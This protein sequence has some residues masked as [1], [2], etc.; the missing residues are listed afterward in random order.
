MFRILSIDGGGLRG[1]IPVKILQHIEIIT[2]KPIYQS[3]DLF[4]GTSTGGLISAGLTVS[5][6]GIT[7]RYNLFDI[8]KIYLSKAKEIFPIKNQ[9]HK[10]WRKQDLSYM[11]K[12]Q[13]KPDGLHKVLKE[14]FTSFDQEP[15]FMSNCCKPIFLSAYDLGSSSPVFFKS[16]YLDEK[17]ERNA[18]LIDICRATSAGPTYLPPY[19]FKYPH[20][21]NE[22]KFNEKKYD[23]ITAIDG[24]VFINNPSLG[25]LLEVFKNKSYYHDKGNL[26]NEDIFVLSIGTGEY[27][28]DLSKVAPKFGKMKWIKPL[29]DIM[30]R[31]NS[32]ANDYNMNG[33]FSEDRSK[34]NY[35]RI[36]VSINEEFKDMANS[37][38]EALSYYQKVVKKDFINNAQ[39]QMDVNTFIGDAQ[40]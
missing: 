39:M 20:I 8:E 40:L 34:L 16:R 38:P 14:F 10:W 2:G 28:K 26:K 23:E 13:F 6:D 33:G 29:I 32:L 17:P 4:A 18:R 9:V 15:Y 5:D 37:T 1:I 22:G 35:L 7:P 25:A 11:F 27:T 12:P 31:G 21:S 30:M 3:F 19:T 36:N 24:G